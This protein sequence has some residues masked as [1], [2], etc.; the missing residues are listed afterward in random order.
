MVQ[1]SRDTPLVEGD[2][3]LRISQ[4]SMTAGVRKNTAIPYQIDIPFFQVLLQKLLHDGFIPPYLGIILQIV[5]TDDDASVVGD[6]EGGTA[7]FDLDFP[8]VSDSV[9]IAW[10]NGE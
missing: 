5:V 7:L 4:H 6:C 1:M 8:L 9:K 3:L 10:R 2:D